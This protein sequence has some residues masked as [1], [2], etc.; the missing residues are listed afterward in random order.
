M[1]N[2]ATLTG[3]ATLEGGSVV[4]LRDRLAALGTRNGLIFRAFADGTIGL[5]PPLCC[6]EGDIAQL[7]DRLQ[8][9]LAGLMNET[10]LRL[11]L[12]A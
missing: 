12:A 6:T 10:D 4:K 11:A 1:P 9:T 3:V 5:A 8:A 7:L 2:L